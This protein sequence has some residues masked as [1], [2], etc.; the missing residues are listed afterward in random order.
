LMILS[1]DES[2]EEWIHGHLDQQTIRSLE[3]IRQR[4]QEKLPEPIG[5]WINRKRLQAV[6][7]ILEKVLRKSKT[8]GKRSYRFLN[9]LTTHSLA[10]I[11][12]LLLVLYA[13]YKFVG[14]LGAGIGVDFMQHEVF[15]KWINPAA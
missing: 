14:E 6:D 3:E 1:G 15:G 5:F 10:G 11:P 4:L 9:T 13:T 12:I 7:Q 8:V 2:L